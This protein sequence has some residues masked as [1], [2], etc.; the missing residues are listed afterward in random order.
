M[1][2][3]K[4]ALTVGF[5]LSIDR[6]TKQ[7]A[8]FLGGGD[9]IDLTGY[10]AEV[11]ID[12]AGGNEIKG[13]TMQLR[14][15]GMRLAD[16]NTLSTQGSMGMGLLVRSDNVYVNAGDEGGILRQIFSGTIVSAF[17]DFSPPEVCLN[18]IAQSGFLQQIKPAAPNSYSGTVD[19]VKA[20]EGIAVTSGMAF[21]N[22]KKITKMLDNQYLCG[23]AI[24]QMRKLADAAGICI[25][26]END[27]VIVWPRD[28]VR[29][30]VLVKVNKSSGMVGYPKMLPEG[31]ELK[32][33]YNPD[34][35]VG[36]EVD[37]DST[38]TS[39]NGRWYTARMTHELSTL[40][41]GG[42]WFTHLKVSRWA[43][44]APKNV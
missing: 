41:P 10:R 36:R 32:I 2:F 24:D 25:S 4:R 42:P 44:L 38:I 30:E 6:T 17:I 8:S 12:N 43:L 15:Y 21:E 35:F 27:K 23:T 16:M 31:L 18:V 5:R 11:V 22:K 1:S 9:Q 28:D 29:D 3:K 14:I 37:I 26:F 33:E 40:T 13:A 20:I 7:R 19:A 39:C 34:V